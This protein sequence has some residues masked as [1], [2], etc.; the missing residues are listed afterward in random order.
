MLLYLQND[1]HS[2]LFVNLD[3]AALAQLSS[4]PNV[5][6]NHDQQFSQQNIDQNDQQLLVP[7]QKVVVID[8][9]KAQR[10][11]EEKEQVSKLL[12]VEIHIQI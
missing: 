2:S 5:H 11:I 3:E 8:Q 10:D 1:D 6:P 12:T 7:D 9:A 4:H